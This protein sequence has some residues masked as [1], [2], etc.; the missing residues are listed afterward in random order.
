[1]PNIYYKYYEDSWT[2]IHISAYIGSNLFH[3]AATPIHFGRW[4]YTN[5]CWMYL[6]ARLDSSFWSSFYNNPC[7]IN[8]GCI[9]DL[10]TTLYEFP[11]ETSNVPIDFTPM[12]WVENSFFEVKS[13]LLYGQ[14]I[15]DAS[16][17]RYWGFFGLVPY[18]TIYSINSITGFNIAI[19]ENEDSFCNNSY[20]LLSGVSRDLSTNITT[21][22][23]IINGILFGIST[24]PCTAN[25]GKDNFILVVKRDGTLY[26]GNYSSNTNP[27]TIHNL[28]IRSYQ[29]ST[30][31]SVDGVD[32]ITL[33][34][35]PNGT[36]KPLWGIGSFSDT[37]IYGDHTP[38]LGFKNINIGSLSPATIVSTALTVNTN[39]CYSPCTI[40]G[41]VTWTNTGDLSTT[42]NPA[43]IVNGNVI[44]LE[45]N[46]QIGPGTTVLIGP[47][48]PNTITRTF[49]L[50]N[51][52]D[53]MYVICA[54]PGTHCQTVIITTQTCSTITL[55]SD[56][57]SVYIGSTI[58]LTIHSNPT[59]QSFNAGVRDQNNTLI[60]SCSTSGGVC[61]ISWQTSL[62]SAGQYN[63]VASVGNQCTS[64]PLSIKL[65]EACTLLTITSDN[66]SAKIGDTILLTINSNPP[67]QPYNVNI[68]DS[69]N[70]IIGSCTTSGGT[71]S[72]NWST[73]GLLA[74]QYNLT[75]KIIDVIGE[76][77]TS[78]PLS[79]ILSKV[80][81]T[82]TIT[83]ERTSTFV[84]DTISLA[85]NSTPSNQ[86]YT[87]EIRDQND[88]LI[89]S[90]TTSGGTCTTNWFTTG[91]TTGQ[92][93]LTAKTTDLGLE[94]CETYPISITLTNPITL[95][96][97]TWPKFHGDIRN[98]GYANVDSNADG[99]IKWEIQLFDSDGTIETGSPAIATDGTIYVTDS[100]AHYLFAINP[101]GTLKW[102]YDL[103]PE[104]WFG[105]DNYP[106]TG[107][108]P[109]PAIDSNGTIYLAGNS[110]SIGSV[111]AINPDGTLRWFHMIGGSSPI[112]SS[113]SIGNDSSIYACKNYMNSGSG[114]LVAIDENGSS[115]WYVPIDSRIYTSPAI[116]SDGR[117]WVSNSDGLYTI[118]PI[119][120]SII[121]YIN[122]NG[123]YNSPIVGND[124]TVYIIDRDNSNLLAINPTTY[125]IIWQSPYLGDMDFDEAAYPITPAIDD[126]NNIY[127]Y[128]LLHTILNKTL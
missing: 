65:L 128:L 6:Y 117:I 92:Y 42:F 53:G 54:A 25:G 68:T 103:W 113:P 122:L 33:P 88:T 73:T 13:A 85:I 49:T 93:V 60:G 70:N 83:P 111:V 98:S 63:L 84:G 32:R 82:L 124:G 10:G 105:Q 58:I 123:E 90:C 127:I 12:N 27:P 30:I 14:E 18:D 121:N 95:M 76:G 34:A 67:S 8:S 26:R 23:N 100:I 118:D 24:S 50:S 5:P 79:I 86:P 75:A 17:R 51:Y 102:T 22:Y 47:N 35:I 64:S 77:C 37:N 20:D 69:N 57:T 66:T 126:D 87:I 16:K 106:T 59:S 4:Y 28:V 40:T 110:D 36:L 39:S 125:E 48:I 62:L 94:E 9:L 2:G 45:N 1:M 44:I 119:S 21:P 43:I 29:G 15:N 31:L 120:T 91:F 72:T 109:T 38:S 3:K 104:T 116:S 89:G 55:T 52:T 56:K 61:A 101:N 97:S 108:Y 71:C 115:K 7:G 96:N 78:S 74:G 99:T 107:F 11:K 80:C 46:V 81:P 41:S 114:E 112:L 19:P